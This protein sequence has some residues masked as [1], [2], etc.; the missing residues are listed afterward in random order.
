MIMEQKVQEN[1]N[2]HVGANGSSVQAN[3]NLEDLVTLLRTEIPDGRQTLLDT[4]SNLEKVADYCAS[5]YLDSNDKRIAFE[6]TKNY[7]T[8]SLASVAYQINTLAY[9]LL[10]MLDLQ[11]NQISEMESQV[12]YITQKVNFHKEKVARREIA[13]LTSAKTTARRP[14][15][16]A[17]ANKEKQGKYIRKPI[18]YSLLD[19]IGHGIKLPDAQ[20]LYRTS[21]SSGSTGRLSGIQTI[22]PKNLM[23]SLSHYHHYN[24]LGGG[25]GPAPTT[26]PPTPP[27]AVR[28]GYGTL[29]RSAGS[30][31]YRALAPPIAPPQVPKNYEP[32]YPIGHPKNSF[33]SST[34]NV[35]SNYSALPHAMNGT[36][37]GIGQQQQQGHYGYTGNDI[38][39]GTLN[40]NSSVQYGQSAMVH[41]IAVP[42]W[43]PPNYLE[44]VIAIYDYVADKDDELTFQENSVIYVTKKN[45]DGWYEGIMNGGIFGLFP[46]NYVEHCL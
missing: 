33:N 15:V 31:E 43:V 8:H 28:S 7:T 20:T 26:K 2:D 24:T 42:D 22:G 38:S 23:N 41:P 12:N 17:P 18:D 44:K 11:T 4:Q 16:L 14:K 6:K 5:A 25:S 13:L 46:S 34:R 45:D 21:S 37:Y 32:N 29:G 27:Q 1:G 40:S 3:S 36:Q 39:S 9:N 19:D 30:K 10:H 35:G